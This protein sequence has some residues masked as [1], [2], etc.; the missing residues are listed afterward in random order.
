[1]AR[2][3]LAGRWPGIP[4]FPGSFLDRRGGLVL[5][6]PE[7]VGPVKTPRG[8]LIFLFGFSARFWARRDEA[9]GSR[10]GPWADRVAAVGS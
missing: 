3:R 5:V 1:M 4:R 7:G 10:I 8:V 6:I 2:A 9:S